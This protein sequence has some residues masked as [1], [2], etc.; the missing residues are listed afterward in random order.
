MTVSS[1]QVEVKIQGESIIRNICFEVDSGT[2]VGI[3]GPNGSGKTTLLSSLY[4]VKTLNSG[5]VYVNGQ[6]TSNISMKE[7]AKEVAVLM[8]ENGENYDFSIEEMVMMGRSPHKRLFE[9]DTKEDR[10]C[11]NRSLRT[12][13]LWEKRHQR[14]SQLSGGEKQRVLIARALTQQPSILFLDEPTNHLDIHHQIQL[15]D[16]IKGFNLTTVAALHDLNLA[17]RVCD[18]VLVMNNGN[19]VADGKPIDV[20]TVDML[21]DV[22]RVKAHV[23]PH[24]INNLQITFLEAM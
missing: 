1:E 24:S 22:F 15:L 11:L 7:L 20:F 4:K 13:G 10:E 17:A 19:L 23:E 3:V 18:K 6:S 2:F 16:M 21:K 5:T 8:Q 9:F 12:V 14:Y